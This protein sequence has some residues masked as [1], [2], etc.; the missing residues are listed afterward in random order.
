M[1]LP[2][3]VEKKKKK[4]NA[5]LS[6][7]RM[8]KEEEKLAS[9]TLCSKLRQPKVHS[10]LSEPLGLGLS[11]I[12]RLCTRTAALNKQYSC[13]AW[14]TE[15]RANVGKTE[16]LSLQGFTFFRACCRWLIGGER[17]GAITTSI[18]KSHQC[19][20]QNCEANV[21]PLLAYDMTA[22]VR[23]MHF[24]FFLPPGFFCLW[25]KKTWTCLF[26]QTL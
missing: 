5:A 12:I 25:G 21:R 23:T 24:W 1:L 14:I 8:K 9:K 16:T 2:L 13:R 17:F 7:R 22:F 10:S 20:N 26:S 19:L 11:L 3:Y 6:C 4:F 15:W 18:I